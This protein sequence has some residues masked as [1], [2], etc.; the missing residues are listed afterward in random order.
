MLG[1]WGCCYCHWPRTSVHQGK[2]KAKASVGPWGAGAAFA[3]H[4]FFGVFLGSSPRL[5]QMPLPGAPSPQGCPSAPRTSLLPVPG[6]QGTLC[7]ARSI[8]SLHAA[9]AGDLYNSLQYQNMPSPP[10]LFYEN[11]K[12]SQQLLNSPELGYQANISLDLYQAGTAASPSTLY[13]QP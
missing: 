4:T 9:I 12:R 10:L 1:A 5:C 2:Q 13:F 8:P 7:V 3:L 11:E 6:S